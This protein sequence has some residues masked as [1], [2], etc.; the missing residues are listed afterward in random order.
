MFSIINILHI[1]ASW[2]QHKTFIMERVGAKELTF[3][4]REYAHSEESKIKGKAI[5]ISFSKV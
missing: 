3:E 4:E 5:K 2:E 1:S